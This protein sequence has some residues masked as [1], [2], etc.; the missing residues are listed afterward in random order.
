MKGEGV[1]RRE[2]M[3]AGAALAA[4]CGLT[5]C[6]AR[7]F[8]Q[9]LERLALGRLRVLWMQAQTCA[10]CSIS[11]LN[12]HSPTFLEAIAE[13]VHLVFH[14]TLSGV[15]GS[16]AMHRIEEASRAP[17]PFVLVVE[18]AIPAR[19]PE[20]CRVAGR[21]VAERLRPL[22]DQARFVVAVGTC[23]SY[24][25]IP[26]AEGNATGAVSV[27]EFLEQTGGVVR[28]RLVHCPGCPCH[29]DE[30]L[31]TLAHLAA[32]GYPA[33]RSGLLT[34][35]MFSA[36]RVHDEC[37]RF[38]MH[39]LRVFAT[40]FGDGEGCLFPLGC[41]GLDVQADCPRRQ[42]N[43]HVNWCIQASAPCIGCNQPQFGKSRST[44]FYRT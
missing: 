5:D 36:G 26:S 18:G 21:P 3:K 43:S 39:N 40:H 7:V 22:L 13:R 16:Q 32:R 29:P 11:L 28:D 41:Q 23:A 1:S 38:S 24:G 15:Q 37:P 34:P 42:W 31:A 12:A 30:L 14:P 44:P 9:G 33:V 6:Y 10:G 19:M 27:K 25:G 4:S 35:V 20:A 8:A 17:E 2:L